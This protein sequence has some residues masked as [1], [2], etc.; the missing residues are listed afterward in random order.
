MPEWFDGWLT[1]LD[2][3]IA[4]FSHEMVQSLNMTKEIHLSIDAPSKQFWLNM[5]VNGVQRRIY[6]IPFFQKLDSRYDAS[7]EFSYDSGIK[8]NY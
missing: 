6:H 2:H 7:Q 4:S 3:F 1:R 8:R 5:N